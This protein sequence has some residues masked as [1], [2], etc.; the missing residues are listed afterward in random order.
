M[1][2]EGLDF[3]ATKDIGLVLIVEAVDASFGRKFWEYVIRCDQQ[4]GFH[5]GDVFYNRPNEL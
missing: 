3:R 4:V 1:T 2:E 5:L